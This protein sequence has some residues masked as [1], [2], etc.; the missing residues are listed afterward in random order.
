M[1]LKAFK[2]IPVISTD[3]LGGEKFKGCIQCMELSQGNLYLGTTDRFVFHFAVDKEIS[4]LG[5]EL[6]TNKLQRKKHL[7]LAKPI[8]Q[9]LACPVIGQLLILSDGIVY[10]ASMIGLEFRTGA[11]K[12]LFK[13]VTAMA[14]NDKPPIFKDDEVQLCIGTYRKTVQVIDLANNRFTLVREIGLRSSP[15]VLALDSETICAVVGRQYCLINCV[16]TAVQDLFMCEEKNVLPAIKRTGHEE[17][18]LNGPTDEMGMVVTAGGTSQHQPLWWTDGFRSVAYSYPYI[19]VLGKRTV[20]VH[21]M[22]DQ[23]QKQ[24]ISFNGGMLLNNLDGSV[25]IA[26]EKSLMSFVAISFRK[27]IQM[28]LIEK[29]VDEAFHLLLVATQIQPKE[30][31][32]EYDKQVRAQAGFIYFADANFKK[33]MSLFLE[34]SLDP[35]EVIVLYPLMMSKGNDFNPSR[36]LLHNIDNL[37]TLVKGSRPIF[38]SYK[39]FLLE[40]MEISQHR[41]PK[42]NIEVDTTLMRVYAESNHSKLCNLVSSKNNI[43]AEESFSW[44]SQFK[45]YHSLALYYS[46]L[47][48]C[49]KAL[50]I[51]HKLMYNELEDSNFPG[52]EYVVNYLINVSNVDLIW[53]SMHWLLD[54]DQILSVKVFIERDGE[55]CLNYDKVYEYIQNYPTALQMYIE[56]LVFDKNCEKEKFHTHLAVIYTDDVLKLLRDTI[57]LEV[58][59]KDARRKLQ[60]LL[61]SSSLY[62]ISV[63]FQ[64]ISNYPLYEE[65]A[66]LYGKMDKHDKALKILVYQLKEFEVAERY[67]N[68]VCVGQD[69]EF[70]HKIF[71]SLLLIYLKPSED[72]DARPEHFVMA[73]IRLLNSYQN[74]FD[75]LQVLEILPEDWPVEMIASFFAGSIRHNLTTFYQTKIETNVSRLP[76][77]E[78]KYQVIN[79]Q[80]AMV[81]LSLESSCGFCKKPFMNSVCVRYPNGVIVHPNCCR[82][83]SICPVTGTTFK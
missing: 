74:E 10:S 83:K 23:K 78:T 29:R 8:K 73:A 81:N 52:I 71:Y 28:L 56:Y 43:V 45:R 24:V 62:R 55:N 7:G 61:E 47:G 9:L 53:N 21:S 77:I 41:F 2:L 18:L 60:T 72:D 17:F 57:A 39:K 32:K 68:T 1:S 4:S 40:F 58:E 30:Y 12:E 26:L 64:K 15:S 37:S 27:Q 46:Y 82:D 76:Y 80:Q 54:Q 20:T 33:A 22:L 66:V 14:R 44:L 75:V 65:I 38:A 50:E 48:Q 5:E 79:L 16:T 70:R 42:A 25:Y 69:K 63:I 31:N 59:I 36:P 49:D 6:H 11:N 67:C 19:L 3:D 13:G 34:S 35:R 51:W